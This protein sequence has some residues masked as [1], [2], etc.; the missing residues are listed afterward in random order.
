MIHSVNVV[1]LI[2]LKLRANFPL[3]PIFLRNKPK[4]LKVAKEYQR[5]IDSVRLR[6]RGVL[7]SDRLTFAI[8]ESL[9]RLKKGKLIV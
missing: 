8:L 6:V 1:P 9:S 7:I 4:G 5:S 3:K 2:L